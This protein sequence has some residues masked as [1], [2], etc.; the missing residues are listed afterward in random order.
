MLDGWLPPG[1]LPP[2]PAVLLVDPPRLPEGRVGGT[3]GDTVVS[4]TDAAQRTARRRRTVL[5]GDRL[6]ARR[7]RLA[8]PRLD[9]AGRVEP[10]RARC[11]PPATTAASASRCWRS[12]RAVE[13][14]A[15]AGVPDARRQ[16]RALGG[17]LG[18]RDSRGAGV[19]FAVDATPGMRTR[20][21]RTRGAVRRARPR[22]RSARRARRPRT[23]GLYTVARPARVRRASAYV[24][25]NTAEAAPARLGRR[26]TSRQRAGPAGGSAPGEPSVVVPRRGAAGARRSSGLLGLRAAAAAGA[27]S[28]LQLQ[29]PARAAVAACPSRCGALLAGRAR[30][31]GSLRAASALWRALQRA[32]SGAA[33]ARARRAA[34]AHA[35]RAARRCSR[36]TNRRASTPRCARD[37][38]ALDGERRRGRLRVAVPGR[39]LRR[40]RRAATAARAGAAPGPTPARP[41]CRARSRRRSGW[42]PRGG[43]VVVLSDGGQTQ[44][45]LLAT[46]PLARARG[47]E[48]DWVALRRRQRAATPRS[49][50]SPCRPSVIAATRCR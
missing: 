36:S 12:S 42:R 37:R 40:R 49:R 45:D 22:R 20:D 38:A 41:T 6:A 11:W 5:A 32:R 48:V 30:S 27:V 34:A 43:R 18:A 39:A 4:G 50:R 15:A 13:P 33:R 16:P 1:G 46:A 23:P 2:A 7:S 19:P 9:R 14:A 8:L 44:G 26:S 3:L 10:R 35:A 47:V 17:R 28:V 31:R 29:P 21:A 25:V 24:A